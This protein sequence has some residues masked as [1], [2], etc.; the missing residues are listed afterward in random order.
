MIASSIEI[1]VPPL[2]KTINQ[3]NFPENPVKTFSPVRQLLGSFST[4]ALFAM[5]SLANPIW[6]QID[7]QYFVHAAKEGDTL[8]HLAKRYLIKENDWLSLQRQ[9]KITDPH[10]IRPG[11]P[12]RFPL[13]EMKTDPA[14]GTVVS[15]VGPVESTGGTLQPGSIVAEGHVIKTGENGFVTIKLAD[16][17]TIVVQSKSLMK[18][19]LARTITGT[20]IPVTRAKLTSGRIE[21]KIEKRPGAV[22]RFEVATPTSNMGV[23]GT[24]FRV[25]SDES[26]KSSTGEVLEGAVNVADASAGKGLDLAAGFGTLIEEGK[27]PIEPVKLLGSPDLSSIA[28]LHERILLRVKFADVAGANGYRAQ[29]A[30]DSAFSNPRAEGVFKTAEAKFGDLPDGS[31]FLRVRA[32]DKSGIEGSDAVTPLVLKARPEPPFTSAPQNKAKFSGEKAD[33]T[34][35]TSTEAGAYRFQLARDVAFTAMVAD[36]KSVR[37]TAFTPSVKLVPGDYFWRASSVRAD[38]DVGPFGDVQT[39]TLKPLP[40]VPNPPKEE[41]GRVSFSWG[42][43][44]GQTFEF[45]LARDAAFKNIAIEKKL[46]KPEIG[47][48]KPTDAGTYFM[49]FRA[50]DPDGFVSPYSS[51]QTFE[52]K[53]SNHW[54]AL[55]LLL[56]FLF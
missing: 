44:V 28:K 1:V 47:I 16:Q 31:Y 5:C 37:G 6:S 42:A 52:V 3:K 8:I 33:F 23:R 32:I 20:N 21:A 36:E 11:T 24:R 46:D 18:L 4:A 53:G 45:Q 7:G 15:V 48:E 55:L 13:A 26:G 10:Y 9:N 54:P 39:F 51:A 2:A 56:P 41:G 14:Q 27:A 34:W 29:V 43:E 30:S 49:R 40:P 38:G 25:G 22:S 35:A 12:I 50:T 17:S 19:D